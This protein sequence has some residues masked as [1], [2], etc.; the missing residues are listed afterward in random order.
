MF[1]LLKHIGNSNFEISISCENIPNGKFEK[2][3]IV[4]QMKSAANQ[5]NVRTGT[6]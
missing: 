5:V 3:M 1:N 4:T 6:R 2:K